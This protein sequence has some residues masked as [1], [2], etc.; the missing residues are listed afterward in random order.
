MQGRF[1]HH[2]YLRGNFQQDIFFD[3]DDF[4]QA[5]NRLALSAEAT[6]TKIWALE[7]LDNH[8][9]LVVE[10]PDKTAFMHYYRMSMSYYHKKKYGVGGM[11][12]CRDYGSG[13]IVDPSEDGGEDLKDAISYV[14]RNVKRHHVA[15]DFY[16]YPWSSV[17]LYFNEPKSFTPID[18]KKIQ[19]YIPKSR[20]LPRGYRMDESGI[21]L[22]QDYVQ[23]KDVEKLF[24]SKQKFH[25]Y[26]SA[27]SRREQEALAK[28]KTAEQKREKR[29]DKASKEHYAKV[30]D[31]EISQFITAE[32]DLMA[33]YSRIAPKTIRQMTKNEKK[34]M[35]INVIR[36]FQHCGLRQLSRIL[37]IP[38]STLREVL[39]E[40]R[41]TSVRKN[42]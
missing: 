31:T 7:Y 25:E 41:R 17:R 5:L 38:T 8:Y 19:F 18:P 34:E 28:E 11:L 15:E 12:G 33:T 16:N 9:H 10:T 30:Q 27:P 22:L 24:G 2:L 20:D 14:L 6:D 29:L 21:I 3:K 39:A 4:I 32:L 42:L 13:S 35:A 36:R 26:L 23:I 1:F 40:P 37:C